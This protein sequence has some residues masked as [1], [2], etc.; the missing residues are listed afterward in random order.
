MT[1]A[2]SRAARSTSAAHTT[3]EITREQIID[4]LLRWPYKKSDE[5][6]GPWDDLLVTVPGSFDDVEDAVHQGL[7][8]GDIYDEILRRYNAVDTAS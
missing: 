1:L 7:L 6:E 5:L 3:G 2:V 8:P 4:E